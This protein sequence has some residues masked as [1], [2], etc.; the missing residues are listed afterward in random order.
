MTA[1]FR[2]AVPWSRRICVPAAAV[3]FVIVAATSVFAQT[4]EASSLTLPPPHLVTT[5]FGGISGIAPKGRATAITVPDETRLFAKP[6]RK[7]WSDVELTP[8]RR[9]AQRSPVIHRASVGRKILGATIGA[10]GGFYVG[11]R[12]GA[13]IEGN[14]CVCD[15]PGL[16]G[17]LIG[18]PIGAVVGSIAGVYAAR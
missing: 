3:A 9:Q 4:N 2:I 14:R 11:G 12:L 5:T 7:R 16:K 8:N 15:D 18:A 1:S 10:I 6:D 13:A 17:F